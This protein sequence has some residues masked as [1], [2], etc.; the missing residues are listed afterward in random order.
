LFHQHAAVL[1]QTAMYVPQQTPA[2]VEEEQLVLVMKNVTD[3]AVVSVNTS[4]I[5]H[6]LKR[7]I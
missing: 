4:E 7:V 6:F 5:K 1:A 3:L 2:H